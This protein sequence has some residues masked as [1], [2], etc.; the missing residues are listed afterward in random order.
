MSQFNRNKYLGLK[1]AKKNQT[2]KQTKNNK[3]PN[4]NLTA[5]FNKN[6]FYY[7]FSKLAL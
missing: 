1:D 5:G 2:N 6:M 3:K 7:Y 4:N